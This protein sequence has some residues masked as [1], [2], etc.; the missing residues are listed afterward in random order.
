MEQYIA[1][2]KAHNQ[3]PYAVID[4]LFWASSNV[5][6][7]S[8]ANQ[9]LGSRMWI[10]QAEGKKP[11]NYQ[12]VACFTLEDVNKI[13]VP[14]FAYTFTGERGI[15]FSPGIE[16]NECA[17]FQ[18]FRQRCGNFQ[19]MKGLNDEDSELLEEA[20][21]LVHREYLDT[22]ETEESYVSYV[23]GVWSKVLVNRYERNSDAREKCILAHGTV[24]SA[25]G[26]DFELKYGA[27]GKG[28]IHIHHLVP[29]ASCGGAY[30]VDPIID[31]TPVCPNCHAMLH[32]RNPPLSINE[33]KNVLGLF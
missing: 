13:V 6:K 1:Y 11:F 16:I 29:I 8:T 7:S 28:F 25:C 24:C 18:N 22:L 31:L 23:E 14:N 2:H 5:Y 15:L 19:R 17:W 30:T 10:V 9:M 27:L 32:K 21:D 33:L 3:G 20:A 4:G 26:F 12:I